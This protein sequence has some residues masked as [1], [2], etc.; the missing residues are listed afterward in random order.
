MTAEQ[1]KNTRPD[2]DRSDVVFADGGNEASFSIEKDKSGNKIVVVD[3]ATV[4]VKKGEAVAKF[5]SDIVDNKFGNNIIVYGQKIQLDG[6]TRDEWQY[7]KEAKG[8]LRKSRRVF[9]D[10]VLAIN[11]TD[12]LLRIANNWVD[13]KKKHKTKNKIIEFARAGI[14]YRVAEREYIADIV[15]GSRKDGSAVL[16]DIVNI[17]QI[18]NVADTSHSTDFQVEVRGNISATTTNI[19]NSTENVNPKTENNQ[20]ISSNTQYSKQ[21]DNDDIRYSKMGDLMSLSLE[22]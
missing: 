1:R 13:E 18:K 14:R 10:K 6:T 2:I 12:E 17:S 11:N 16:Y 8:L 20:N 9:K 3:N 7:S 21:N 22:A 15:V 5:I 4:N 19:P